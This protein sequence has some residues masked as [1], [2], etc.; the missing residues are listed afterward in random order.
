M[1]SAAQV[2]DAIQKLSY[3]DGPQDGDITTDD[4][5]AALK[6]FQW[7]MG[8]GHDGVF[9]EKTDAVLAPIA[10]TLATAPLGFVQARR[11]RLTQ[12]WI[13]DERE[14]TSSNDVPVYAPNGATICRVGATFFANLSLEGSG[15]TKNGVLLNVAGS[16]VPVSASDYQ[17]VLDVAKRILSAHVGYA[18]IALDGSGKVA[19]AF[20]FNVVGSTGTGYGVQRGVSLQPYR[21]LA[22]D[23]GDY[24]NC[25]PQ[26]KGK[27]GLVPAG[28][29]VWVPGFVG[30][31]LPDG[32][33]HDGFCTVND[34]GSAI[35]GAHFDVFSGTAL[36]RKAYR[37]P[38]IGHVWFQGIESRIAANYTFG[39]VPS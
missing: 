10:N 26:F 32:S 15:R 8:L 9:G 22:A 4:F 14:Y 13:A 36:M 38:S 24:K 20:A 6:K 30:V 37:P 7:D 18:G 5:R 31:H 1:L 23:L 25:D 29:K 16:Y 21:T 33:V 11:W 19:K 35:N 39:L 12:Y 27:G 17:P 28:T 2:Q 34:T 3:Y